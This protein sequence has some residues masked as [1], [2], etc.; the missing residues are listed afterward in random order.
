MKTILNIKITYAILIASLIFWAFFAFFTMNQLINTQEIYAKLINISGKQRMLSQKTTLMVKRV[1][2]TEDK[3]LINHLEELILTMKHD[4]EFLLNNTESK[5]IKDIYF[6]EKFNLDVRVR[7]YISLL[8]TFLENLNNKFI[9]ESI[10]NYSFKLLP[11]LDYAVN[12]FEKESEKYTNE[13]KNRE[14]FILFGTLLTIFLEVILIVVP[15]LNRM[16]KTE[17]DLKDLNNNLEKKI[18]EQ[19]EM[20]LAEQKEI[21]K[22]DKLS[23]EQSKLVSMGEMIG[24][25]AHQWR[26]PLSIITTIVSGLSLKIE[27][28]EK[29]EKKELNTSLGKVLLQANYL[30]KTI[31]DFR[32]FIKVDKKPSNIKISDSINES[33]VLLE[34]SLKVNQIKVDVD[35]TEDL[36]MLGNINE[37][38]QV[39]INILKNAI[40]AL[41][42]LDEKESKRLIFIK[43]KKTDND[44]FII[45]ILDNAGGIEENI[46]NRVFEPYFTTKHATIGTGIGLSMCDKIIRERYRG[47]ITVENKTF[48]YKKEKY[49]GAHFQI[50]FYR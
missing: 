38:S 44:E 50:I 12:R 47:T 2:E 42:N 34:S 13:L 17:S 31:D 46:L 5:D 39:L 4:H 21:K 49:V 33:L 27:Y 40:D 11:T 48:S 35:I 26:Q 43:T 29:I 3:E 24:N 18:Q 16:I 45:S 22:R 36:T 8:E 20:I 32:N 15:S 7:N 41:E 9:V 23:Y 30:S 25:I 10:Q 19:K 14:L 37:L 6:E 28:D 1:Y